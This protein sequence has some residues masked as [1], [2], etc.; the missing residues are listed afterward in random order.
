MGGG[1]GGSCDLKNQ[2]SETANAADSYYY[3]KVDIVAPGGAD[4]PH[5]CNKR[6]TKNKYT[7]PRVKYIHVFSEEE[8]LTTYYIDANL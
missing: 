4:K 2:I 6:N 5:K 3:V 8:P 1:A 7:N